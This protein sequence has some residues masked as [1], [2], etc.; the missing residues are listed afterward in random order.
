MKGSQFEDEIRTTSL[1][2]KT[3]QAAQVAAD[4]AKTH[5]EDER[6]Q[7]IEV[8][9]VLAPEAEDVF[10]AAER[11]ADGLIELGTLT[12]QSSV[13]YILTWRGG[14]GGGGRQLRVR[15]DY[16]KG[17]I[18]EEITGV[19]SPL[20]TDPSQPNFSRTHFEDLVRTLMMRVR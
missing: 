12:G 4:L 17:T 6:K 11:A 19:P 15:F 3:K 1:S 5:E 14:R 16:D 13:E 8:A 7:A 10:A 18:V 9:R 20:S 2:I